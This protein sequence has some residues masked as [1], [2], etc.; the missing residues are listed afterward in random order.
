MKEGIHIYT[1]MLRGTAF[2]GWACWEVPVSQQDSLGGGLTFLSASGSS[3]VPEVLT[4]SEE[5]KVPR[6]KDIFFW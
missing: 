1:Q 4:R 5:I 2:N 6:P 3:H